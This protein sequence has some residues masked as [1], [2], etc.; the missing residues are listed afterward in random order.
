MAAIPKTWSLKDIAAATPTD[1]IVPASNAK[2]HISVARFANT[3][4][5]SGTLT[6]TRT[7]AA[8]SVV[9]TILPGVAIPKNTVLELRSLLVIHPHKIRTTFSQAL[10]GMDACGEEG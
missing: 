5:N 9:A 2:A 7:D 8:N 1:F 3:A 4:S 6:V 10:S